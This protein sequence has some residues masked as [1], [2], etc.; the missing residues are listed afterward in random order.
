MVAEPVEARLLSLSKQ[1]SRFGVVMVMGKETHT[2][3]YILSW[4]SQN[5]TGFGDKC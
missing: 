5:Q 3:P 4:T 1:G 2:S